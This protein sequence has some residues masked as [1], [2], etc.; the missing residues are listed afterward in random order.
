VDV[1]LSRFAK[2]QIKRRGGQLWVWET[3]V[4]ESGVGFIR[5][6]SS[7][8]FGLE[9]EAVETDGVRLW[10]EHAFPINVVTIGWTPITGFAVEGDGVLGAASG[11]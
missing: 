1:S 5:T 3:P 9:F 10:F 7:A 11:G 4:G 6:A 2:W 8:P